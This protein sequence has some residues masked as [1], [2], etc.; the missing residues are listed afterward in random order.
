MRIEG[1]QDA[2][3]GNFDLTLL[4]PGSTC[5]TANDIT[6]WYTANGS[7][8]TSG[9]GWPM[10]NAGFGYDID[11]PA[12]APPTR[13]LS[14]QD[15]FFQFTPPSAGCYDLSLDTTA[16]TNPGIF[17]YLG[18]PGTSN[19]IGYS[20]GSGGTARTSPTSRSARAPI[21]L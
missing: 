21:T 8:S 3:L 5:A 7:Y 17:V 4:P 18:C 2:L 9:L 16:N 11:T 12:V 15:Y 14:G 1:D 20:L 19:L 6:C 10:N 13:N